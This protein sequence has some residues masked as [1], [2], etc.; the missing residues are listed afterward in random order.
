MIPKYYSI[1][2][3]LKLKFLKTSFSVTLRKATK[4]PHIWWYFIQYTAVKFYLIYP[5]LKL[6]I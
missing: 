5:E 6:K 3:E 4:K 1:Y 2:P